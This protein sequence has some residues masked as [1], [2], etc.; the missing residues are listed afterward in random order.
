MSY[1]NSLKDKTVIITGAN[2]GIGY[3]T[4]L[5]FAKRGARLILACRDQTRADK[6]CAN[7]KYESGNDK[8]E[9]ELLDLASLKSTG[10]FSEKMLAKLDRL[11]ILVNNAG[12]IAT[13]PMVKTDEGFELHFVVNYLG[14][15][16]CQS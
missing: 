6:A 16:F 13:G 8:V 14:S 15:F 10:E 3:E 11:D 12:L 9:V 2:T 1:E 5:D 4:A 7:I